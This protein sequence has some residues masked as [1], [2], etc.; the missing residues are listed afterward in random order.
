MYVSVVAGAGAAVVLGLD[1]EA[2]VDFGAGAETV[3][4]LVLDGSIAAIWFG[5]ATGLS[6]KPAPAALVGLEIVAVEGAEISAVF[7]FVSN[8]GAT[9]VGFERAGWV[10][11][12]AVV[13]L[14]SSS[15][16]ITSSATA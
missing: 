15:Q 1:G 13:V 8:L 2:G 5:T 3:R 4:S 9:D 10:A 14:V 6:A 11:D 16:S 7:V 12:G